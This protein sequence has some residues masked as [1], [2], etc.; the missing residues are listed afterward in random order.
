MK[1]KK[2]TG[3]KKT[4]SKVKEKVAVAVGTFDTTGEPAEPGSDG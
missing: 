4:A 1:N 2:K 3:G